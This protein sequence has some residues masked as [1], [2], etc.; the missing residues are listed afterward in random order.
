M[1]S[2]TTIDDIPEQVARDF[3]NAVND[4]DYSALLDVL[5][6][7]MTWIDPSLPEREVHGSDAFEA[8]LREIVRG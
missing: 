6:E 8:M 2:H 7:S 1:S 5:S 4:R 3:L